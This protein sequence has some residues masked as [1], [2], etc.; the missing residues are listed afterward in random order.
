[1]IPLNIPWRLIGAVGVV[2][3]FAFAGW[4][5]S[6][7]RA[8]YNELGAVQAQLKAE[9]VCG[10]GSACKARETKLREVMEDE[11]AKVVTGLAEE[12]AAVGNRPPR[13]VRLCPDRTG[14]PVSGP[15]PGS[16]AA[17]AGAGELSGSAGRDVGAGLYGLAREA[18]E[19]VAR[20]RALQ[21]WN[22]ALAAE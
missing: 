12:L 6:A 11:K 5:I 2:A 3:L 15:T 19:I 10:E 13:V 16:N 4:R 1:M 20:C 9:K 21:D 22:R 18:D 17:A 8:A 7:W 14:V